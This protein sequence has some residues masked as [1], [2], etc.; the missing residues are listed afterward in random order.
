[1]GTFPEAGFTTYH[2]QNA[3]AAIEEYYT[4]ELAQMV[5]VWARADLVAFGYKPWLPGITIELKE[6]VPFDRGNGGETEQAAAI[7]QKGAA[8]AAA[9][10]VAARQR[11]LLRSGKG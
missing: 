2:S 3:T 6:S 10:D 8:A 9:A 4:Y 1:V 11:A 7:R 5:N